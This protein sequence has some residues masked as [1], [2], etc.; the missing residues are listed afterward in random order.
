M[1]DFKNQKKP[2]QV[3]KQN[4]GLFTT[5]HLMRAS[6]ADSCISA[7]RYKFSYLCIDTVHWGKCRP[8]GLLVWISLK[9]KCSQRGFEPAMFSRPA[10]TTGHWCGTFH[11]CWSSSFRF[12]TSWRPLC[13]TTSCNRSWWMVTVRPW[14]SCWI[15]NNNKLFKVQGT[16]V[17]NKVLSIAKLCW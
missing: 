9:I 6:A 16:N 3:K 4:K 7:D 8:L 1:P 10:V 17:I 2:S 13:W 15:N 5:L 14:C 12:R 11:R